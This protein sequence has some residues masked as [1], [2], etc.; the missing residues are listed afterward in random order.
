M[1]PNLDISLIGGAGAGCQIVNEKGV[2]LI[3]KAGGDQHQ[4]MDANAFGVS[5]FLLFL[6][7]AAYA[8]TAEEA[9]EMITQ[10]ITV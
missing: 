7:V 4:E 9:I 10:G 2:S 1:P 3:L 6:H 8:N 5:W